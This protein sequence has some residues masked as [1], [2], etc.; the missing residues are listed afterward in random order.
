MKAI[1]RVRIQF[2]SLGFIVLF[3]GITTYKYHIHHWSIPF[4]VGILMV[5]IFG[6]YM[7]NVSK[8]LNDDGT[9]KTDKEL[10]QGSH[11]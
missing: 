7:H 2:Y 9:Y 6:G 3:I 8:L 4:V 5:L 11:D 1:W 10:E